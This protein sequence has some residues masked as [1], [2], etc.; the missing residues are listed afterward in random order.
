M[1]AE[2]DHVGIF[3]DSVESHRKIIIHSEDGEMNG[4]WN[5]PLL[6]QKFSLYYWKTLTSYIILLV[7]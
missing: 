2:W 3:L 1:A 4:T 5:Q 7:A 6:S